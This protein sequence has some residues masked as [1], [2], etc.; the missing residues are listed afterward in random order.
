M[1]TQGAL[2]AAAPSRSAPR[3]ARP[4]PAVASPRSA[5]PGVFSQLAGGAALASLPSWR[6][7]VATD[8][9]LPTSSTRWPSVYPSTLP[10]VWEVA[11][12]YSPTYKHA[13][14]SVTFVPIAGHQR[15]PSRRSSPVFLRSPVRVGVGL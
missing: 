11:V 8:P 9:P 10:L 6:A 4:A 7:M 1:W 5:R 3:A 15:D 2:S 12:M 14:G 13:R